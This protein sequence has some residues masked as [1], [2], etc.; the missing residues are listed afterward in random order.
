[1]GFAELG[2]DELVGWLVSWIAKVAG[3][4]DVADPEGAELGKITVSVQG[5][6]VRLALTDA[7]TGVPPDALSR[8]IEQ[9]YV[10]AYRESLRQV[11]VVFDRVERDVADKPA[12]LARIRRLRDEYGDPSG[13]RRMLKRQEQGRASS[14]DPAV[15]PLR[16]RV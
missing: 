3:T 5:D 9:G 1:M 15:D 10:D 8:A 6:L 7:T 13:L 16:R 4:V 11:G 2:D 14:W 12:V